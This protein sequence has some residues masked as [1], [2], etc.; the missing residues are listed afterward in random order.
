MGREEGGYTVF[1][2]ETDRSKT[3]Q[4]DGIS[5]PENLKIILEEIIGLVALVTENGL[6]LELQLSKLQINSDE[7][8]EFTLLITNVTDI[9]LTLTF[10]SGQIFD[11]IVAKV[12]PPGSLAPEFLV[13]NWAHDKAFTLQIRGHNPVFTS[14]Y[15]HRRVTGNIR[16]AK[17]HGSL[18]WTA[19]EKYTSGKPGR[20]GNALVVPPAPEKHPPSELNYVWKLGDEILN[21]SRSLI[22]FGFA[23]NPYDVALL[24]FLRKGGA[25][26]KRVLL[27]DPYP[28]TEA[29]NP[30]WPH[31][32]V[33]TL[34][35]TKKLFDSL[36]TW[37]QEVLRTA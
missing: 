2:Q 34:F 15:A 20:A 1:Y 4:T 11:F 8:V 22:V 14:Q 28:N 13:W 12:P 18:S 31:A 19:A 26:L 29:A 21:V 6:R 37:E 7:K 27:V 36:T 3:V 9:P 33:T 23:F 35:P 25:R 17:L 30:L 16:I 5:V 24:D 10:N 32:S